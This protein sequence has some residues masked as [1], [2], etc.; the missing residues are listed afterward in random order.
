MWFFKMYFRNHT[1]FSVGPD[2]TGNKND[3][4][5]NKKNQTTDSKHILL[6]NIPQFLL[7]SLY[8]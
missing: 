6:A 8:F 7:K 5:K 1:V 3:N 2:Q 4:K